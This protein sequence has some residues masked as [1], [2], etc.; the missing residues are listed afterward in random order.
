MQKWQ[1]LMKYQTGMT[2]VKK[3]KKGWAKD[4]API[5]DFE[6]AECDSVRL[7]CDIIRSTVRYFL[8]VSQTSRK[9]E[10][11]AKSSES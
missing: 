1:T 9:D 2:K 11:S 5:K 3:R 10:K 4:Y 6:V 7:V 8:Q